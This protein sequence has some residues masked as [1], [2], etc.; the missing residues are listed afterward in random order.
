MI[1]CKTR[2]RV[3]LAVLLAALALCPAAQSAEASAF[4]PHSL[5][6][7]CPILPEPA[8]SG[9]EVT[10]VWPSRGVYVYSSEA[11]LQLQALDQLGADVQFSEL[12]EELHV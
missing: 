12:A 9:V 4:L 2:V 10:F 1:M 6:D 5:D 8:T 11:Q 3:C 7:I